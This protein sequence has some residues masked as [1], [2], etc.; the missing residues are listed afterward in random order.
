[1]AGLHG[2]HGL[3]CLHGLHLLGLGNLKVLLET[4]TNGKSI[5]IQT[6][7]MVDFMAG[8]A[9]IAFIAFMAVAFM[10]TSMKDAKIQ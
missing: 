10:V 9:F 6:N 2:L 5:Q 7:L 3:H 8:V 1:M 4:R